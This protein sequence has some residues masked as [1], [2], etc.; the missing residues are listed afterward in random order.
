MRFNTEKFIKPSGE[1]FFDLVNTVV[2]KEGKEVD[3]LKS[4]EDV[5]AWAVSAGVIDE[6]GASK[7][8]RYTKSDAVEF[9]KRAR[10][11]RNA[12]RG[13]A[14]DLVGGKPISAG[15]VVQINKYLKLP[16][17]FHQLNIEGGDPDLSFESSF[18]TPE[19][20]LA[21]VAADAARLLMEGDPSKVKQCESGQC[22]LFFY[23][24][25]KNHSRRWCSM[26]SCGNRE[27]VKAFYKRKKKSR[28]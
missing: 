19:S 15:T 6:A 24:S 10:R 17:G 1:L 21:P 9:F 12:L 20:L 2:I 25:T 4:T 3:L 14:V 23:D 13:V 11:F 8:M 22:V 7:L 16:F 18:A 27:K 26:E 5:F 28:K